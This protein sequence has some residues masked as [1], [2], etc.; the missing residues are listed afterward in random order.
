NIANSLLENKN[1]PVRYGDKV[2]FRS[3]ANDKFVSSDL[4]NHGRLIASVPH[5]KEW[6]IF[7]VLPFKDDDKLG[8]NIE[9]EDAFTLRVHSS[10]QVY[11]RVKENGRICI[12][13]IRTDGSEVFTFIKPSN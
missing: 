1:I 4:G 7:T 3:L 12:D 9:Y 13:S 2:A 6:E 10:K 8:T 11:C 5:I